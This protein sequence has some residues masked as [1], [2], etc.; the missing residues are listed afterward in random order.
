MAKRKAETSEGA[1]TATTR[2]SSRLKIEN[3]YESFV[4]QEST[5]NRTKNKKKPPRPSKGDNATTEA[6]E[7]KDTNVAQVSFS[8]FMFM[9]TQICLVTLAE[10]RD[11][12]LTFAGFF[13]F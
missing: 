6:V 10:S 2:R 9:S 7:G 12:S 5:T 4:S 1:P 13:Q 8:S 3:K 11:H